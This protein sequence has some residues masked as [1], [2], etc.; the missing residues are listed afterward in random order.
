M[1]EP[2]ASASTDPLIVGRVSGVFGTRGWIKIWSHTRPP[3]NILKYE[4]WLLGG[5]GEWRATKLVAGKEHGSTLIAQLEGLVDRDVAAG[6]VGKSIAVRRDELPPTADDEYYWI[7][8]IG[9]RVVNRAGSLL[10]TV[11]RCHETGSADVLEVVG[12]R[13]HLIP[14]V[15]GVY[16]DAVDRGARCIQVDWH[17]ED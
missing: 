1:T 9:M 11:R 15:R 13:E 2:Q 8:L 16:V 5:P 7:E 4:Y 14:F 12:E 17:E 10:G 6:L 3:E